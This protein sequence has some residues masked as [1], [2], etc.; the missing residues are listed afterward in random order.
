MGL[1]ADNIRKKSAERIATPTGGETAGIMQ[2][3]AGKSGKA[4]TGRAT[5]QSSTQEDI[6]NAQAQTQQQAVKQMEY[7]SANKVALAEQKQEMDNSAKDSER[8]INKEKFNSQ[9]N[10]K[11]DDISRKVKYSNEDLAD[12]KDAMDLEHMG[13][14][15]AMQDKE[16]QSIL[17]DMGKR[18]RLDD[19]AAHKENLARITIGGNMSNLLDAMDFARDE[20]AL[21]REFKVNNLI[22]DIDSA[23]KITEAA[24]ADAQQAAYVSGTVGV[25]SAALD[26]GLSDSPKK[27]PAPRPGDYNND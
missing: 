8:E 17:E 2:L 16:Y 27:E 10:M 1:L 11:F 12:R 26:Y 23:I 7:T 4:P 25:V 6:A 3:M 5:G 24:L 19:S 15:L 14:I 9:L 21:E 20:G 13:F 18:N 22:E